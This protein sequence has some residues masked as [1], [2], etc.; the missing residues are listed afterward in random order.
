MGSALSKGQRIGWTG[1]LTDK[2]RDTNG[3][4]HSWEGAGT[5]TDRYRDTDT[6]NLNGQLTKKIER[7]KR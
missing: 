7:L 1:T 3:Q 2:N 6:D 5:Q 4:G